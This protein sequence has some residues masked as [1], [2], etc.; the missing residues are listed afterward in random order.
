M[1]KP[2]IKILIGNAMEGQTTDMN[3]SIQDTFH[4]IFCQ[5]INATMHSCVS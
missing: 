5:L 2:G 3:I 1:F 4:L